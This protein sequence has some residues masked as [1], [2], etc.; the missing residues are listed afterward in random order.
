MARRLSAGMPWP[1]GVTSR[2]TCD[3]TPCTLQSSEGMSY[4]AAYTRCQPQLNQGNKTNTACTHSTARVMQAHGGCM[5]DAP[6]SKMSH[7]TETQVK[8]LVCY[9]HQREGKEDER[10]PHDGKQSNG[11]KDAGRSE[12]VRVHR[13]IDCK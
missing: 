6:V 3:C 11:G 13:A 9:L 7:E 2:S 5:K 12:A 1:K 8:G 4:R 10:E